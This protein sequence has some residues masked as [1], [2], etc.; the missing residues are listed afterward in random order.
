MKSLKEPVEQD[1]V[2]TM[3]KKKAKGKRKSGKSSKEQI[4]CDDQDLL[5]SS[6]TEDEKKN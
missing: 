6:S 2:P 3:M 1:Q 4:E 5:L